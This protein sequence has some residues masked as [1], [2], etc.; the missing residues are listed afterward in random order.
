MRKKKTFI[1]A[2]IGPNHNGSIKKALS[3]IPKIAKAGADAIKFQLSNVEKVYSEDAF[4]A[5]YQKKNDKS[6]SILEMGKKIQ[7]NK[8]DHF[9]LSKLCKKFKTTYACSAF[10]L[11]SLIFLDKKIKVKFFKIPSGEILSIDMLDYISKSNK[12]VLMSTGM[13]T[14]EE[15]SYALKYLNK[16]KVKRQIILLHCVSA[17]PAKNENLNLNV[18]DQ[19][20]MKFDKEIGYSDHSV[21]QEASLAAVAKGATVI[22]K[23][24]TTS[25]YLSGPD[26]K[27]SC[28]IKDFKNL[29][30]KIRN[31]EVILG[32]NN[33]IFS[34]DEI[35]VKKVARKSIVTANNITKGQKLKREDIVFKRPGIGISPVDIKKIL[36]RRLLKDKKKNK[37]IFIKDLEK[38]S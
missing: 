34:K 25:R 4:K 11:D 13:S 36:G 3:M 9:K 29:V 6:K 15:I 17:Y 22:E 27:T 24:V 30:D 21:G 28:T 10:D 31:L 26:H 12:P 19:L 37:L 18:I 2:E 32:D 5:D 14:F 8:Q 16:N 7:L 33:K 23:H 20:R 1:I 35:N 38:N